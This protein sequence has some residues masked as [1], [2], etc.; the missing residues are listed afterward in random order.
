VVRKRRLV[1][2]PQEVKQIERSFE[3]QTERR[4]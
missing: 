1:H 2:I 4:N 3:I